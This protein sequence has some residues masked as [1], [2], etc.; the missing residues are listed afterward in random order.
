MSIYNQANSEVKE[1]VNDLVASFYP[2]LE[3]CQ[4]TIGVFM[5][6]PTPSKIDKPALMVGGYPAEAHIRIVPYKDRVAGMADVILYL[7]G[8]NWYNADETERRSLVDR[9]LYRLEVQRDKKNNAFK[10]DDRGRP[11]L[12]LK[13]YDFQV[14]GFNTIVH[15]YGRYGVDAKAIEALSLHYNTLLPVDSGSDEE[16]EPATDESLDALEAGNDQA[17][18]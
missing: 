9:C 1:V 6:H 8:P 5:V 17:V 16:T 3:E 13:K 18:V 7:D 11:T 4:A 15:R 14:N 12:K 2:D 10:T